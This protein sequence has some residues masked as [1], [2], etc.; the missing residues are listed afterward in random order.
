MP[1]VGQ[2]APPGPNF[3]VADGAACGGLNLQSLAKFRPTTRSIAP[4]SIPS[5][6]GAPVFPLRCHA[7]AAI[8]VLMPV[9]SL[10]RLARPQRANGGHRRFYR[11]DHSA[12]AVHRPC[13]HWRLVNA[14][15]I[16][17]AAIRRRNGG[18]PSVITSSTEIRFDAGRR[19]AGVDAAKAPPPAN[20]HFTGLRL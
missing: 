10:R 1:H 4:C 17:G 7:R 2:W 3:Q 13:D 18:A 9:R 14:P 5:R 8:R 6:N 15:G 16:I 12:A 11:G 19:Y 20:A